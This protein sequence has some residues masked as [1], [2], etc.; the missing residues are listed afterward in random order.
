MLP[1][2]TGELPGSG[3][4]LVPAASGRVELASA[5]VAAAYLNRLVGSRP[6]RLGSR[7]SPMAMAQARHV[8]GLLTAVI[9]AW[10]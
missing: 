9:L 7:T 10:T 8:A 1:P 5:A 3:A 2:T 6:V 4:E